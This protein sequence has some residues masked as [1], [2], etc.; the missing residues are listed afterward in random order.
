MI[1]N[2]INKLL[3]SKQNRH[4]MLPNFLRLFSTETASSQSMTSVNF[5][6]NSFGSS[7]YP[8]LGRFHHFCKTRLP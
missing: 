4:L 2:T 8:P 6:A 5:D 3:P 7:N 1:G